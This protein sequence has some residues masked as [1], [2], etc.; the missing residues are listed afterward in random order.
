MKTK[1]ELKIG[2]KNQLQKS[3]TEYKISFENY[4][5]VFKYMEKLN[6]E[7]YHRIDI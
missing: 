6:N 2:Q 5:E 3:F 7:I 1:D 4:Q